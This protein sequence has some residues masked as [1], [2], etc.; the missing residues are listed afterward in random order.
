MFKGMIS[1]LPL[2]TQ[3]KHEAIIHVAKRTKNFKCS[4]IFNMH[5]YLY[6]CV[7][8]CMRV[9]MSVLFMQLMNIFI[10]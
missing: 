3:L 10:K 1:S 5:T 9:S 6:A 8:V 2:Y 4:L 7:L